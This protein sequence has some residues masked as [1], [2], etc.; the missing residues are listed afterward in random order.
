MQTLIDLEGRHAQLVKEA[1]EILLSEKCAAED[2]T[3]ADGLRKEAADLKTRIMTLR[4]I[5]S[6]VI[7]PADGKSGGARQPSAPQN[8][9]FQDW[10]EFVS[11]L[12]VNLK[13]KGA[14][15]D[16]RF[17]YYEEADVDLK[18]VER[19]DLSGLTGAAG[20]FLLPITQL[21]NV[22]GVAAPLAVVRRYATVIRTS[23]RQTKIPVLDQTG[24]TA[25]VPAFFGAVQAYWQEEASA[26]TQSDMKFRQTELSVRELI[27]YTVFSNSLLADADPALAD[28]LAGPRGFPG[29]MAWKE[30]YSF[31][32]GSGVGEPLGIINAPATVTT[33]SRT[34][35]SHIKYDDL[36]NMEA[37]F[38]GSNPVWLATQS[39]KNEL[40][41]MNGPSGNPSYLWGNATSGIPNTLLGYPIFFTDKQPALGTVGDLILADLSMY[42]I[43]DRQAVT[44]DTSD[45]FKFQNN[46]T[47]LRVIERVEGAPWLSTY[48]TL[49]DGSTTVSPFVQIPT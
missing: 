29:A 32:R 41:L 43:L 47:A 33:A 2:L 48:I 11:A 37:K 40:L 10:G 7:A 45:Q 31:I 26:A 27:A 24:T 46:Q 13:S 17:K 49:S 44:V 4:E 18:N 6:A 23:T 16:R 21:S 9:D 1:R 5:D 25:G 36:A 34:T 19:K 39:A 14:V 28:L 42:L 3:R 20:G 15:T 30:D 38:M 8:D 12:K 22:M 35:S